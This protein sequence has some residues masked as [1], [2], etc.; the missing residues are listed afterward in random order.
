M[1]I[2]NVWTRDPELRSIIIALLR[3]NIGFAVEI[4]GVLSVGTMED[5]RYSIFDQRDFDKNL[6]D[7]DELIFKDVK[8]AVDCFLRIRDERQLGFD[9]ERSG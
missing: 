8:N 3:K 5:G 7:G 1:E 2:K 4:Y 9:F 6:E